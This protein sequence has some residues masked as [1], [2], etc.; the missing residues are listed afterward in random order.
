MGGCEV[1]ESIADRLSL[2]RKRFSDFMLDD[3][4][5]EVRGRYKDLID[6]SKVATRENKDWKASKVSHS[7]ARACIRQLCFGATVP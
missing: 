2:E 4:H 5:V 6:G 3:D 1:I 7:K